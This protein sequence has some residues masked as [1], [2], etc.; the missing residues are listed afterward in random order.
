MPLSSTLAV[1]AFAELT[2]PSGLGTARVPAGLSRAV[3]L[4]SGTGA[5]QAD[6]VYTARRT[7][8]ANGSEDLDL[9]GVLLD[10]LG[11]TITFAKIK[12]MVIA[13][14]AG[15]A[16]SIVIG[17]A[18]SNSWAALLN[19]TGTITLR[20]GAVLAAV[21]GGADAT[22]YAVTGSTG[23]ILKVANS[24]GGSAVTY[25]ICIVGTSA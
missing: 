4:A 2:G 14:A 9:A 3:T 5:G 15:N 11:G 23:D 12:G 18:A 10:A 7:I 17:A 6:K 21:A 1:S 19:A 24:G 8:A 25:D 16:N 22:A 20:P 13:A